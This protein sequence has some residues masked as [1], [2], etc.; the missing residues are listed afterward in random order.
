MRM[1]FALMFSCVLAL[2]TTPKLNAEVIISFSLPQAPPTIGIFVDGVDGI[3]FIPTSNLLVS[4]LGY[5]D[6]QGDG[7]TH[8]HPVGIYNTQTQTLVAP[9]VDV[10]N[11]STLDPSI[12][13]R[14][15]DVAPF[16]LLS[17]VSYTLAGYTEGP[18]PDQYIF[19]PTNGMI[20]GP[21][22]QFVAARN[23]RSTGLVFPTGAS[24][25][26]VIQDVTAG[27]N[28]RYTIVAVPELPSF[29]LLVPALLCLLT[30]YHCNRHRKVQLLITSL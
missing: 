8:I 27:P 28:F 6:H 9:A 25:A 22:I 21:E 29:Y 4:G 14:F 16:T 18:N 12:N 17:G 3:E 11:T 2:V 23:G 13:F 15:V 7:L 20:F 19:S 1:I 24:Q 10:T 26:G 30:I 5:Y